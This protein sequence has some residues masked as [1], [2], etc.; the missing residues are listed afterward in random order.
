MLLTGNHAAAYGCKLAKAQVISAYPITPHTEVIEK[1]AEL[2]AKDELHA[3]FVNVESEHSVM[4]LLYGAALGGVRVFTSTSS[5]GLLYMHEV[6][7]WVAGARLPIV[8]T[9]VH[10]APGTPWNLDCDQ[11]DSLSQRDTGWIQFYCES[12]QDVLD[13]IIQGYKVAER[14]RLPCMISLDAF[15]LSHTF[16]VVEM[17]EQEIVDAYL[18]EYKPIIEFSPEYPGNYNGGLLQNLWKYSQRKHRSMEKALDV[19]KSSGE[20]YYKLFGRRLAPIEAISSEDAETIIATS[21]TITRTAR[22]VLPF[23]RKGGYKV[24][25]LKMRLFRPFP[26]QDVRAVLDNEK[27]KNVIVFDRNISPGIGGI[28]C[29]EVKASLYGAKHQPKIFNIIVSDG[30]DVTPELIANVVDRVQNHKGEKGELLW[31]MELM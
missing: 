8:M 26:E 17:P 28:F 11:R 30:V 21:D 25:L 29:Q 24:G 16:E 22:C 3:T 10:R 31:G 6:L 23:L 1:I 12:A 7:H 5:Q 19:V 15:Y 4:S 14:E 9:N 20:D 18:G 13:S 2:R 27:V